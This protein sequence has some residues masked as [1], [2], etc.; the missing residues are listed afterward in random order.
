MTVQN[1][2]TAA[3]TE[4]F[5]SIFCKNSTCLLQNNFMFLHNKWCYI[6]IAVFEHPPHFN[7][8]VL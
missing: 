4:A 7:S 1:L 5:K 8:S 6:K 2:E 3:F